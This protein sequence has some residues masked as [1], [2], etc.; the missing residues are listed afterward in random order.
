M[1]FFSFVCRSI[2]RQTDRRTKPFPFFCFIS[3]I[4]RTSSESTENFP[5]K[6]NPNSTRKT[7]L[8]KV[9][10]K[11]LRRIQSFPEMPTDLVNFSTKTSSMRS[12]MPEKSQ[13]ER[14]EKLYSFEIKTNH[15]RRIVF[16]KTKHEEQ[17]LQRKSTINDDN[18]ETFDRRPLLNLIED[19]HQRQKT[20]TN[21]NISVRNVRFSFLVFFIWFFFSIFC[22]GTD[23]KIGC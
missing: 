15:Y 8:S 10:E 13:V 21:Q 2:V 12:A 7:F 18:D 22:L 14:A 5:M 11:K 3:K 20:V 17:I 16:V 4:R 1:F 19:L 9:D 23:G 6:F